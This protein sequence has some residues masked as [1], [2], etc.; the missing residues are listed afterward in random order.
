MARIDKDTWD[1]GDEPSVPVGYGPAS[2]TLRYTYTP[3]R[4]MASGVYFENARQTISGKR[5]LS[6][7]CFLI[8]SYCRAE[9]KEINKV[10]IT[11]E[12]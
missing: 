2:I 9:G 8:E 4:S 3:A 10:K 5:L 7:A 11:C 12:D 6:A 1:G